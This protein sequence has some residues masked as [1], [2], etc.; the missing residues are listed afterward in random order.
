MVNVGNLLVLIDTQQF[1]NN[2]DDQ[3]YLKNAT[4]LK[5]KSSRR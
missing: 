4:R 1:D 2:T 3:S 5:L